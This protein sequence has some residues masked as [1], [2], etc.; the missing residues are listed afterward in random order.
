MR[1]APPG[2]TPPALLLL[3][4]HDPLD[5]YECDE[6]AHDPR[7]EI[8]RKTTTQLFARSHQETAST[9]VAATAS[10][11]QVFLLIVDEKYRPG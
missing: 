6:N 8:E 1:S 2:N 4:S 5:E 3:G 10:P 7:A 9:T 11:A